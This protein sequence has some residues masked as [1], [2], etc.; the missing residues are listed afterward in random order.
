MNCIWLYVFSTLTALTLCLGAPCLS[1]TVSTVE[2]YEALSNITGKCVDINVNGSN[3]THFTFTGMVK[4][5]TIQNCPFLKE[6]TLI[7][8]PILSAA[9]TDV[10]SG[11]VYLYNNPSLTTY[12][13][14]LSNTTMIMFAS[15]PY[16]E[17]FN[18]SSGYFVALQITGATWSNLNFLYAYSALTS[19]TLANMP[20]I[21]NVDALAQ[22]NAVATLDMN[23]LP[24]LTALPIWPIHNFTTLKL[25]KLA[26]TSLTGLN[27]IQS[28]TTLQVDIMS[29]LRDISA[30]AHTLVA[31][32]QWDATLDLCCPSSASGF[33]TTWTTVPTCHDCFTITS[34][35]PNQGP[36]TAGI[37]VTLTYKGDIRNT[38]VVIYFGT[39]AVT[40]EQ[41]AGHILCQLPSTTVAG[42][43]S[44]TYNNVN[45]GIS[46]TYLTWMDVVTAQRP[47]QDNQLINGEE[48]ALPKDNGAMVD[49]ALIATW[50][51]L[52]AIIVTLLIIH[53]TCGL[54]ARLDLIGIMDGNNIKRTSNGA[55]VCCLG[56]CVL[57][58]ALISVVA[59]YGLNNTWGSSSLI[60]PQVADLRTS[61]QVSLT[62]NPLPIDVS[63]TSTVDSAW[64]QTTPGTW[65][66][67]ACVL[68]D[69]VFSL[70]TTSW[71]A[72]TYEVTW[73]VTTAMSALSGVQNTTTPMI[74]KGGVGAV[75][76]LA[77]PT[78]IQHEGTQTT[79]TT[80]RHG[81]IAPVPSV[82]ASQVMT[83]NTLGLDVHITNTENWRLNTIYDRQGAWT[84]LAQLAGMASGV[85][86][87]VR[88]SMSTIERRYKSKP[89]LT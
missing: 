46:F 35:Q 18:I 65:S 5:I 79:G 41:T 69:A 33:Y 19:V 71:T 43:V 88:L 27:N 29:N 4:T 84:I 8:T 14:T 40:C 60:T 62:L 39:N 38:N 7:Q 24:L 32:A 73:S 30:L 16:P 89:L 3:I 34:I 37:P 2:Q 66:C 11:Y 12:T 23:N 85:M 72:Y 83:T 50:A 17:L 56:L 31:T 87:I 21:T 81:V 52:G 64:T 44:L 55:L 76:V 28:I 82:D 20:N 22:M 80:L 36:I 49:T 15:M 58:G 61:W 53:F 13:I 26:L 54:S 63:F 68:S 42:V 59:S 51:V 1:V 10:Y 67:Q 48:P 74:L 77:T 70:R 78:L 75:N 86:T 57:V 47:T 25:N 9:L 45:L 6:L